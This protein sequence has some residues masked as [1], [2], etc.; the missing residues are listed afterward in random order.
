MKTM[1]LHIADNL[2]LPVDAVTQKFAI[3]G[4][5]G[6]GKSYTAMKL[7]ELMLDASA[8]VIAVDPVGIWWSLRLA[9]DGKG[10]GYKQVHVFG[11]DHGDVPLTPESGAL[12]GRMLADRRFSAVLDIS[13]FTTSETKR[14]ATN[15]AEQFFQSKKGHK[16]PVHLFLE[17]CQTIL[18]QKPE[19]DEGVMLNRWER[20]IKIGRNYGAGSSMISQQ[21]QSVNKRVLNLADTMFAMRTIGHHE[22]AAILKWVQDVVESESGLVANLPRLETG[23]AHIWSPYWLKLSSDIR[24]LPRETFDAGKTPEMGMKTVEPRPL[25]RI[26]VEK[27]RTE[28][29]EM[30]EKVKQDDPKELR[31]QI[32]QLKAELAKRPTETKTITEEKIVE[33]PS[34]TEDQGKAFRDDLENVGNIT[35]QLKF[36]VA[37]LQKTAAIVASSLDRAQRRPTASP[38]RPAL[39]RSQPQP[40]RRPTQPRIAQGQGQKISKA[41]R[42]ILTAL[43][44]LGEC[45]KNK[46]AVVTGYAVG[47]GG[48]NNAISEC[49]TNGWIEGSDPLTLTQA[50]ADALGEFSPL[51]AGQEL[52]NHWMGQLGKAEREVLRVLLQSQNGPMSKEEIAERTESDRGGPYAPDGGG[53]NNAISRL[54]T[55]ELISGSSQIRLSDD[56]R[57]AT[58]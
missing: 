21:P 57:E 35:E 43:A 26:D 1:K 28:M 42:S 23:V 53:F 11:G 36:H 5:S 55:L 12:I 48:F 22:R 24:I 20:L 2:N 10:E 37:E 50:G 19:K 15:F 58:L 14:F 17:E 46:I 16:S 32:Q 51:P 3:L 29:A 27:L 6:S 47:G 34:V 33:V 30:I 7:A 31:K 56:L 40:I 9:A 49:R 41:P 52:V 45:S 13:Q 54:R 38:A 4:T 8:Q 25:T 39:Q 44:Q 18:P